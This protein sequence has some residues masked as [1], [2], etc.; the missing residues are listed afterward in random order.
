M[1]EYRYARHELRVT[2]ELYVIRM[3]RC[4]GDGAAG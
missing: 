1:R 3:E 2:R 4:G